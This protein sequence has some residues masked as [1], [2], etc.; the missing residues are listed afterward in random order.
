MNQQLELPAPEYFKEFI[1]QYGRAWDNYDIQTILD[2]YY[3]PCFIFKSGKV[4]ANVTE[5]A[6]RR[7]FQDLLVIYRQQDYTQAII[8]N[9]E[10]QALGR[11]SALI[12]V[13]WVCKRAD[14]SVVFD[15]WDSYHVIR[16][17]GQWKILDDTV[18]DP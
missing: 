15:F 17:D 5:E 10:V 12:T 4:F 3:T 18:H 9:F 13:E 11:N 8:P 6:K 2:Y 7:Y 1:L 14:S 16:I